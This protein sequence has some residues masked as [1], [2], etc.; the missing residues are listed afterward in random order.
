M[1]LNAPESGVLWVELVGKLNRQAKLVMAG[2]SFGWISQ[3]LL[4]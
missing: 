4:H 1:D 3:E 2:N